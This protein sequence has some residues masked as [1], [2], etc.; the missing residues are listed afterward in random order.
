MRA[1]LLLTTT[2]LTLTTATNL[3]PRHPTIPLTSLTS[4]GRRVA[5]PQGSSASDS[6]STTAVQ[7]K[8]KDPSKDAVPVPMP[9]VIK[10]DDTKDTKDTKTETGSADETTVEEEE[11]SK[12]GDVNNLEAKKRCED[13]GLVTCGSS[14]TSCMPVGAVCCLDTLT[15]MGSYCEAG[16]YCVTE[17]ETPSCKKNFVASSVASAAAQQ[18]TGDAESGAERR[19]VGLGLGMVVAVVAVVGGL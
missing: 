9:T 19:G 5:P 12:V 2:L 18:K 10:S 3:L 8:D 17:G 7:D 14:G 4:L 6:Q 11:A 15:D 16:S 1:T 13:K